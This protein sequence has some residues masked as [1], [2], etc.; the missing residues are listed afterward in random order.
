MDGAGDGGEA[1]AAQQKLGI[2]A[3]F[4]LSQGILLV[5]SADVLVPAEELARAVPAVTV[6]RLF[7]TMQPMSARCH[8]E[9][10]GSFVQPH[11][12]CGCLGVV[13]TGANEG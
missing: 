4:D 9:G 13:N 2:R 8:H 7:S 5:I 6:D 10:V 11:C 12:S 1:L 3:A